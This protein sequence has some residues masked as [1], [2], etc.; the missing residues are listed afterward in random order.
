MWAVA[1]PSLTRSRTVLC[2][3]HQAYARIRAARAASKRKYERQEAAER[4]GPVGKFL[5]GVVSALDFQEDVASDRSTLASFRNLRTG[6]KLSNQQEGALKRKIVGT[7]AGFF[8]E[9]VDL[10]GK[11]ADAGY[12]SSK[13]EEVPYLWFLVAVVLGVCAA[14]VVVVSKAGA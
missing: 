14:T 4:G 5:A 11:Y 8:G 6:Q 12:V 7:K 9:S 2:V 13:R 10:K 1:P 3:V